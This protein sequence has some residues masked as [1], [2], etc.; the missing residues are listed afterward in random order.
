LEYRS[1]FIT[2][3]R[4]NNKPLPGKLTNDDQIRAKK[5]QTGKQYLYVFGNLLSQGS[6]PLNIHCR[7]NSFEVFFF[8]LGGVCPSKWLPFRLV[9][10]VWTLA[11]FFFVQSYTSTLFT[12]VVTPINP[13]LINSVDDIVD[14][15]DI[16]LLVRE[17]GFLNTLLLASHK[18]NE[19]SQS[20]NNENEKTA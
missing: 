11:A 8:K 17:T 20:T 3:L 1:A 10:G 19:Y 6:Q 5:W 7:H 15:G 4:P 9:A 18:I 13:P 16:N 14:S 12:Y 2:D